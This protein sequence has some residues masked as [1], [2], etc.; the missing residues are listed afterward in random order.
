MSH[1]T[2]EGNKERSISFFFFFSFKKIAGCPSRRPR[3][4]RVPPAG[5][6]V[7]FALASLRRACRREHGT[8]AAAAAAATGL[9]ERGR[10]PRI[11]RGV[12]STQGDPATST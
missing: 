11:R 7:P 9:G 12:G 6:A 1:V 10:D 5:L 8:P 2:W 4:L 3:I